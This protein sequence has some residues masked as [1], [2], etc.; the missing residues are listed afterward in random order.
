MVPVPMDVTGWTGLTSKARR[1]RDPSQKEGL[2]TL[3]D[4]E[5]PGVDWDG[6]AGIIYRRWGSIGGQRT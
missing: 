1:M 4:G 5:T 2:T 3:E 6:G